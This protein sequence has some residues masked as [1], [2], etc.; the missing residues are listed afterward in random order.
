MSTLYHQRPKF[1]LLIS[2][3]LY[4]EIKSIVLKLLQLLFSIL[5][6]HV[7]FLSPRLCQHL[8]NTY[9]HT[10]KETFELLLNLLNSQ[11][12][13]ATEEILWFKSPAKKLIFTE[14][15]S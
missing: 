5:Y 3:Q 14:N 12:F 13:Q 6:I 2:P 8:A 1:Q 9:G 15:F 4:S 10:A 7:T 11:A